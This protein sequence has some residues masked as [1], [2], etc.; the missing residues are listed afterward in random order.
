MSFPDLYFRQSEFS[1]F[2]LSISLQPRHPLLHLLTFP[3][4][5]LCL[6]F[7]FLRPCFTVINF[8]PLYLLCIIHYLENFSVPWPVFPCP[9]F[10]LFQRLLIQYFSLLPSVEMHKRT[11]ISILSLLSMYKASNTPKRYTNR[12][13]I[14]HS[15]VG[16]M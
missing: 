7:T 5:S 1:S 14:M 10:L 11:T 3:L 9:R 6:C 8:S 15:G 4:H 2:L 16:D 13:L 12:N